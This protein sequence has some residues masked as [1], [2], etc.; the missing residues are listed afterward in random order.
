MLIQLA[1]LPIL[2]MTGATTPSWDWSV[3]VYLGLELAVVVCGLFM[4]MGKRHAIWPTIGILPLLMV[5]APLLNLWVYR[6]QFAAQLRPMIITQAVCG[7]LSCA[8]T[9]GL[10]ILL[11][12]KAAQARETATDA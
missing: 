9:I 12:R 3:P 7:T 1:M 10:L 8:I 2:R 6:G 11:A 4:A 5:G